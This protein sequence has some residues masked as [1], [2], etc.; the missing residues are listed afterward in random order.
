MGDKRASHDSLCVCMRVCV[1]V[2]VRRGDEEGVGVS[3][4]V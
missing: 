3:V 4:A 1:L 2:C